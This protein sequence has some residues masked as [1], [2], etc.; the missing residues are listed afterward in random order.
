M[1]RASLCEDSASE[2]GTAILLA[3]LFFSYLVVDASICSIVLG[4]KLVLV[5]RAIRAKVKL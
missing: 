4:R 3:A 1:I 2:D 5:E